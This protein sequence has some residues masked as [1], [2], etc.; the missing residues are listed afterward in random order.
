LMVAEP[1][2]AY[3]ERAVSLGVRLGDVKVPSL[4]PE[5]DW[6]STFTVSRAT[7]ADCRTSPKK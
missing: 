1:L 7:T 5:T 4:R 6:L 2:G 3:V